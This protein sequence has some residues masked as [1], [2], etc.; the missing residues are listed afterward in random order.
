MGVPLSILEGWKGDE[1]V[2]V[3]ELGANGFGEIARNSRLLRPHVAALLNVHPV[4]VEFFRDEEG[5]LAA[6]KEILKGLR[7][8]GTALFNGDDPYTLKAAKEYS[9]REDPL[10]DR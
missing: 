7:E 2:G 3:F 8:E 1:E 10:R 4:H 5:V 9:G 6:K